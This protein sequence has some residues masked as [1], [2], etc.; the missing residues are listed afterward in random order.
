MF[1]MW[2]YRTFSCVLRF[3]KRFDSRMLDVFKN[4]R[5]SERRV[6]WSVLI[7]SFVLVFLVLFGQKMLSVLWVLGGFV[8]FHYVRKATGGLGESDWE[9]TDVPINQEENA[10]EQSSG[11]LYAFSEEVVCDEYVW[12]EN[13]GFEDTVSV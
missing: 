9:S 7:Y 6:F 8:S 2:V 12:D 1:W 4:I 13:N 11:A 10:P 5:I 3:F